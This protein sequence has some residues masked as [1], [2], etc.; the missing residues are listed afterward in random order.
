MTA[1][2]PSPDARPRRSWSF[3]AQ[4]YLLIAAV[5]VPIVLLIG[6]DA[7]R[8]AQRAR[9]QGQQAASE[10]AKDAAAD[11][12]AVL[13]EGR[14]ILM[15]LA[16]RPLVRALDHGRC[17]PLLL[18]F[19]G[20]QPHFT[21]AMTVAADGGV[22]C[23]AVEPP[24]ARSADGDLNRVLASGDFVVGQAVRG[25]EGR[26]TAP[27]AYP[28][29]DEGGVLTGTVT[30]S[31][32]L[33]RFNLSAG[34]ANGSLAHT[35]S[36]VEGSGRI[37]ARSS[38]AERFVGTTFPGWDRLRAA[39]PV[40]GA[41]YLKDADGEE[42]LVSYRRAG[43]SDWYLVVAVPAEA[44]RTRAR[45]VLLQRAVLGL[46]GLAL[47]MLAA[48]MIRRRI[49][50]P[51]ENIAATVRAVG[52]GDLSRRA[53]LAGAREVVEL[54]RQFNQTL[55]LLL[56]QRRRT[57]AADRRLQDV[58]RMVDEA[59]YSAS[60]DRGEVLFVSA[61]V[62]KIC[63]VPPEELCGDPRRW[64][65]LVYEP[66]RGRL[67]EAWQELPERGTMSVEYRVV[68]GDGTLRWLHD[69]AWLVL[70]DTGHP[71]RVDGIV[72]D[73]TDRRDV[74]QARLAQEA[75][76]RAVAES[77]PA[78]LLVSGY[79]DGTI[80]YVNQTLVRQTG[81]PAQA[82]L[83]RPMTEFYLDPGQHEVVLAQL[84][85]SGSFTDVEVQLRL[86]GGDVR[87]VAANGRLA[88]FNGRPALF[89][90]LYDITARKQA[91]ASL[92]ASEQR[93]RSLVAAL[94]EGVLLHDVAGRVLAC[95]DAAL[96]TLGVTRAQLVGSSVL[97]P[98]WRLIQLDGKPLPEKEFPSMRSLRT[99]A[100]LRNAVVGVIRPDGERRWLEVSARPLRH[101]DSGVN[102]AAV[103][104]FSDVTARLQAERELR[105]SERRFRLLVESTQ[106]VVWE[107]DPESENF[108]YVSPRAE[109]MLGY[110]QQEWYA[111]GFWAARLH[112]E[113][114][115]AALAVCREAAVRGEDHAF[116]Y[117]LMAA[118]GRVVW[119]EEFMSVTREAD[120]PLRLRGFL[121]DI[122]RRHEAEREIRELN[123]TLERRVEDRTARLQRANAELEAFSYSVSHDLRAPL[124]AIN[125]FAT[126][127]RETEADHLSAE[128]LDM[129]ERVVRSA[130]RMGELIDDMLQFSRIGRTAMHGMD[131]DMTRLAQEAAED[132]AAAHPQARFEL[133][134]LPPV[135]GDP[136]MLRQVFAN[137]IGN[138]FKFSGKQAAA[139]V[140]VGAFEREGETVYYVRDNGVGFDMTYSDRLFRVFQRLHTEAEFPGTGVGLAIAKRII[141]RHQGRIWAESTLGEGACFY[142]V[143]G[144]L[145]ADDLPP[146]APPRNGGQTSARKPPE[147]RI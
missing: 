78:A 117:R 45:D 106:A 56:A 93:F 9:E 146:T 136:S 8:E 48:N 76:F 89:A 20:L 38:N 68:R 13:D 37:I 4:L 29:R 94:S 139:L 82:L 3:R 115:E 128:S 123:E 118:D 87:W 27:L 121:F 113:D 98:R 61:A 90:G 16:A 99:G 43:D 141:E 21:N 15:R 2:L 112:P 125:G 124:R 53:P 114:R 91:E 104:S 30:L 31:L 19:L 137:L 127:L 122:T 46:A 28:L 65:R 79:P 81:M 50:R 66:D 51:L 47:V 75:Q 95:N 23:A 126:I 74:E 80:L 86:G 92:V 88:E 35:I 77:N 138:A 107:M 40:S 14:S 12:Q 6:V 7:Y 105:E 49:E 63:G 24:A 85:E 143:L 96:Q 145:P 62:D 5:A 133:Q 39:G 132:P 83:G 119:V 25:D 142:F 116:E 109:V 22:R 129:L 97:D 59:V 108:T 55:D 54:G 41:T 32:D 17:D 130:N 11:A 26:W 71:Q 73:V 147:N 84:A 111:P 33:T 101:V 57:E 140:Q 69:R 72:Q 135:H 36:L 131:V 67:L 34:W 120:R 42:R 102:Y 134:P 44:I 64:L 1:Q 100:G 52:A 110:P 103:V 18:E 10:L 70:D 144:G 60:A 58:L